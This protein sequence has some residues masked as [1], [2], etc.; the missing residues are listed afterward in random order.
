MILDQQQTTSLRRLAVASFAGTT[1]EFYDFFA[2]GIAAALVFGQVFFPALDPLSGTLA[3]FS[4]Y[5]VAFASRPLGSVVF[6]HFGDRYGRKSTLVG[7]LLLMGAATFAIGLLPGY[8]SIGIAAPVILVVLRFLQGFGLGGEWGGAALLAAEH[9]PQAKRGLYAVFP[10]LGPTVGFIAANAV[11]LAVTLAVSPEAFLAWGWR[12]PFLLSA[13]LV[14]AG[15]Y[16]RLKVLE[17]PVFAASAPVA[18]PLRTVVRHQWRELLLGSGAMV[19]QYTFFYTATAYCLAYTTTVLGLDRSLVLVLAMAAIA[20]KGLATWWGAGF[21]QRY[22]RRRVLLLS[23][24][25]AFCWAFVLF[26]LLDTADPWL[27]LLALAGTLGV[28]GFG[29]GVMG[30]VLPELFTTACRYTGAGLAYNLG[31][32]VGGALPPIVAT[33]LQTTHGSSSV[34]L[35]LAAMAVLSLLCVLKLPE[36]RDRNLAD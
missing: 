31:G 24:T 33:R 29:Y 2:Y 3:S 22:G 11:F 35:Y 15:L 14:M 13:T 12:I 4:T 28:A 16:V 25:G 1:I 36:T 18:S 9:A 23:Y 17:T 7:A 20:A 30:A 8:T 19:V 21:G 34:A 27:V 26:P 32:V 10:Q 5:A 6:G